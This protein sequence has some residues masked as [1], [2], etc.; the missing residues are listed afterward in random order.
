MYSAPLLGGAPHVRTMQDAWAE[1]RFRSEVDPY[2]HGAST[3]PQGLQVVRSLPPRREHSL[4]SLRA[5][6]TSATTYTDKAPFPSGIQPAALTTT[7]FSVV[8]PASYPGPA[9]ASAPL[10][11]EAGA[12]DQLQLQPFT[13]QPLSESLASAPP[14]AQPAG[15]ASYMASTLQPPNRP[16]TQ[17]ATYPA[18]SAVHTEA[19]S[20]VPCL[21]LSHGSGSSIALSAPLP[22]AA[23]PS[24]PA[25]APAPA[26]H[27]AFLAT[28]DAR[29]REALFLSLAREFAVTLP[30]PPLPPVGSSAP[31][32]APTHGVVTLPEEFADLLDPGVPPLSVGPAQASLAAASQA[33]LADFE[34]RAK[35]ARAALDALTTRL[36][37]VETASPGAL[38]PYPHLSH[39]YADPEAG[40]YIPSQ[41]Q[42]MMHPQHRSSAAESD[43]GKRLVGMSLG[44][45]EAEGRR[46]GGDGKLERLEA[47]EGD[48][49]L[50]NNRM[51]KTTRKTF[52]T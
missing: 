15:P 13:L 41:A 5:P 8:P 18:P 2:D 31:P 46:Q 16:S 29:Q 22:S 17:I 51:K 26:P 49:R 19:S 50:L 6:P 40:C 7:D 21:A 47:L 32:L 33:P 36:G 30:A 43:D 48:L 23:L 37:N 44:A 11:R 3:F 52:L 39:L 45:I 14:S 4:R 42:S 27:E 9:S 10:P 20:S 35:A 24:H 38:Q 34:Q 25:P 1:E 12:P 28:L